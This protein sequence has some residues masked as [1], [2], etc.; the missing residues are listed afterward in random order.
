LALLSGT[1][2]AQIIGVLTA[3]ILTRLYSPSEFGSFSIYLNIVM[4]AVVISC[5]RYEVT[6]VLPKQSGTALLLVLLSVLI[7]GVLSLIMWVPIIAFEAAIQKLAGLGV[8][9]RLLLVLPVSFLLAAIYRIASNWA[10]RN[11]DYTGLSFSKLW[12]SLPQ[13]AG[14]ISFGF[15]HLGTWG[16]VVGEIIGRL[17][18]LLSLTFRNKEIFGGIRHAHPRRILTLV[19]HYRHYPLYSSWSVL[20]NE[21]GSVAPVFFL[22]TIYGPG[23]AGL[24]ALVQRVFALPMDL[25]GQTAL[26]MYMGEASHAI[27]TSPG[28]LHSLFLRT[29]LPLLALAAIPASLLMWRGPQLFDAIFGHEWHAAGTYAQIVAVAYGVRMAVSPISQTLQILGKQKFIL[30]IEVTRLLSIVSVFTGGQ[31]LKLDVEGVL[32][33]YAGVLIIFQMWVLLVTWTSTKSVES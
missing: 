16:L 30:L 10:V 21:A 17:L 6:I 1:A 14:Q 19:S 29:V 31:F 23:T 24:F 12:Q 9:D 8:E 7:A 33:W 28:R 32:L 2:I 27:R 3:P 22:A 5:L 18:G 11:K 13:T 4:L 15:L 20:L 26:T 25:I